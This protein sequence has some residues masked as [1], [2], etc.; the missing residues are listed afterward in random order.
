MRVKEII[1]GIASVVEK[2]E[3]GDTGFAWKCSSNRS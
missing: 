3:M 2:K 1:C